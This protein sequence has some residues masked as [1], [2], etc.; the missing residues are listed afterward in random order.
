ML[1]EIGIDTQRSYSF[2]LCVLPVVRDQQVYYLVF[3]LL[4]G[5]RTSMQQPAY[6][7]ISGLGE[8][9]N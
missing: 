3:G 6:L 7:H 2:S 8:L 9:K 4:L 5:G 1:V